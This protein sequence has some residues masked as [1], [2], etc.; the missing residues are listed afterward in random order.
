MGKESQSTFGGKGA[1]DLGPCVAIVTLGRMPEGVSA[2]VG[3]PGFQTQVT[4]A[5]SASVC[6]FMSTLRPHR[7]LGGLGAKSQGNI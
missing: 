1:V 4:M 6:H 2:L 5:K 3:L 7:S